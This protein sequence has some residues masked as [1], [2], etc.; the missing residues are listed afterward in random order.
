[1]R[2]HLF[3]AVFPAWLVLCCSAPPSPLR[4]PTP[5]PPAAAAPPIPERVRHIPVPTPR[6]DV[7]DS[8]HGRDVPD[9]YRWLEGDSD[10]V[11]DWTRAQN[12]HTSRILEAIAGRV[13][14]HDAIARLLAVGWV[15]APAPRRTPW[16]TWRYFYE[17]HDGVK[18][19]PVV[20]VRDGLTGSDV[21]VVDVNELAADGTAALDWFYPSPDGRRIAF[22]VSRDGDEES[23]LY[24]KEIARDGKVT[25]MLDQID[26]TRHCSLAWKPDGRGFYYTRYPKKG[27]VPEGEEQYHRAVFEHTLGTPVERD[28]KV[29]GEGRKMTDSPSVVLSPDGRWLA[30]VVF[31]GWSKT[32]LY[33]RDN[34]RPSNSFVPVAEGKEATY[35]PYV[36]NDAIF[37]LTN[38]DAP[39]GRTVRVDPAK[40]QREHWIPIIPQGEHTLDDIEII[41]DEIVATYLRDAATRV[42]RYDLKGRSLGEIELPVL[43]TASV[44]GAID[45]DEAFVEF[46]SFAVK[47]EVYRVP[48]EGAGKRELWQG[49]PT[50]IPADRILVDRFFANSKDGT[51]IPYFVVRRTDVALDGK[52]PAVLAAY[53][54]FNV[55]IVPEYLS[56]A[57]VLLE[58]G[59]V[60]VQACLRGGGEF[61]ETWHQ[62]GML[63][64]K[65][66]VFDDMI[67]VAQ[68][69]KRRKIASPDRL[70]VTGGSNGGL[71]VGAMIVQRPELFRVAVARVPLMDM[72]RYHHFLLGKL[73]IPEY[74][75]SGDPDL[76]PAL[77]AYSPYHN[78][79][80][81]AAYPATLMTA[82]ESDSRVHP[83]HARKMTAALQWATSSD[84]P[85][86]ARIETKAGHGAGKPLSKRVEEYTDA[87]S[88]MMWKLG[89]LP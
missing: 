34:R 64:R 53:G 73:W 14:V 45:G 5:P 10:Q 8:Y 77:L 25:Q 89:M 65:Q 47:S 63:D 82:A 71:L 49:V 19:Q 78:V 1:M 43:G 20:Y 74:G 9:P 87:Y 59:A 81:G 66:N 30:V 28:P 85:I 16:R 7:I 56:G 50:P 68:D 80:D 67:A 29:F 23:T 69:V 33:V 86:L 31:Q 3:L 11:A 21:V 61:G 55:P 32:E 48:L 58:R 22:G 42:H 51:S 36:T 39:R 6:G 41:G 72:L 37:L 54:G 52:A 24:V 12:E 70:G 84:E 60:F 17:R 88:F 46:T 44:R 35:F 27:D 76:F 4:E 57:G 83:L 18:N 15:E 2:R 26:R 40:P 62:A 75:E 79:R 13:V 38:D